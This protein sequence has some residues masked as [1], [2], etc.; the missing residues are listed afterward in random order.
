MVTWWASMA[1][2]SLFHS[3]TSQPAARA[4]PAA[5]GTPPSPAG[6]SPRPR[7][8]I[9]PSSPPGG[10]QALHHRPPQAA[11]V[12]VQGVSLHHLADEPGELVRR[13]KDG[14]AVHPQGE[15]HGVQVLARPQRTRRP[16]KAGRKSPRQRGTGTPPP[17]AGRASVH[18]RGT[19]NTTSITP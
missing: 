11:D 18:L 9:S 17:P 10:G 3:F 19:W 6:T 15:G 8:A 14:R 2:L 1:V 12:Q 4:F 16:P 7:A 5:G 13:V